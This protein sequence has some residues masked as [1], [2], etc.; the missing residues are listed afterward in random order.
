M[1]KQR[2]TCLDILKCL[3]ALAVVEI[4]KPL[5]V[6]K[7]TEILILC[8][9]AVPVFFMITG[10]FYPEIRARKREWR[11]LG[12]IFVIA[13]CANLFYLLWDTFLAWEEGKKISE[14]L[15]NRLE[16]KTP[17]DYILWNFSPLVPHLWYLQALLY[18]LVLA[19][20]VE[21]L[22]L[23]KLAYLAIPVLLVGNLIRG[24][25]SLLFWKKDYCHIYYARNFLYCGLP[26]FW[27][28]CWFGERK[29]KLAAYLN[30]KRMAL[31]LIG[32]PVFWKMSLMERKWLEKRNVLGS[33]EEYAGTILMAICIFL[34]FIGWQKVYVENDFTRALAKIGKE[35]SMYI[36]IFHYAVLQALSQC[37]NDKKSPVAKGYQQ[38]GMIFIF[39]VTVILVAFFVRTKREKR[40]K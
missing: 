37:L 39:V 2:W 24:N 11:Q 7:G 8:R 20:L 9:F 4:H 33:E 28:G 6:Q 26:F 12:K 40:I 5:D 27:L 17:E 18:V 3:A 1:E 19:A 34:F 29:E 23:R 10:F 25:Y 16:D 31:L 35:Y 14:I 32:V 22:G 36:Y 21:Y 30:K 15:L 13:I 38:Y